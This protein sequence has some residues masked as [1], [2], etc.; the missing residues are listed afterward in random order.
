MP[1]AIFE[2]LERSTHKNAVFR[3]KTARQFWRALATAAVFKEDPKKGAAVV[4]RLVAG[5]TGLASSDAADPPRDEPSPKSF[6]DTVGAIAQAKRVARNAAEPWRLETTQA[7]ID[8]E[9]LG[10][11]PP[12]TTAATPPPLVLPA[13]SIP[14]NVDLP[15]PHAIHADAANPE[16][17]HSVHCLNCG[18]DRF[19]LT[20][21]AAC[22]ECGTPDITD[23]QRR[24]C[25]ALTAHPR[26]LLWRFLRLGKLPAGW[27]EVFDSRDA[28]A[29]TAR[30]AWITMLVAVLFTVLAAATFETV[31]GGLT[32][33]YNGTAYLYR[34]GD[35]QRRMVSSY[36]KG[37][38]TCSPFDRD[39]LAAKDR[40]F[41]SQP[42]PG[43]RTQVNWTRNVHFRFSR[44]IEYGLYLPVMTVMLILP[45]VLYRYG[46]LNFLLRKRRDLAP[47]T[48]AAMRH[49]ANAHAMLHVSQAVLF[50]L[51]ILIIFPIAI[52]A[53]RFET[54]RQLVWWSWLVLAIAYPFLVWRSAFRADRGGRLFIRGSTLT[55]F[56]VIVAQLLLYGL[57]ELI[58]RMLRV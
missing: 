24:A 46:W 31:T 40:M 35:P 48:G 27:W 9:P 56:P 25:A 11:P 50:A 57:V 18:Y 53:T 47:A 28:G 7:D 42:V 2:V 39:A 29:F 30:G 41:S 14:A 44:P 43:M 51:A 3:H 21:D 26:R 34:D 22:P 6:Y 8:L 17:A 33:E 19:G 10:A 5:E 58:S 12:L 54:A 49:A 55:L 23:Q 1:E 38:Y 36:G 20:P 32:V 45:W 16:I 52:F 13:P 15:I 37:T 4:A